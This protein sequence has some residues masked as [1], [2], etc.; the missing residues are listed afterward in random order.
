MRITFHGAARSV[1]GSR[2]LIEAAGS[3]ILLD[4]GLFQGHRAEADAGNRSFGFDPGDL[5]VMV[6]SHAHIDHSG[7]IPNLVKQG[8]EGL[9]V[10]TFATRDLAAIMLPDSAHIQK[11]DADYLNRRNERRG[12]PPVEP[13][14]DISDVTEA[15]EHFVSIPYNR[16]Y[17]LIEGVTMRFLE[18]GH[19]L[20]SAQVELTITEGHATTTLLFSGDLG[21]F[22][23]PILRDPDLRSRPDVLL[24]ES[25]YGDRR[26]EPGESAEERLR[27]VITR[28]AGR[29]GKLIVPA[30]SVGR[31][32]ALLFHLQRLFSSGGIPEIPVFVD[33]PLSFDAT[34]VYRLHPE[35]FDEETRLLLE[36]PETPFR[37]HNLRFTQSV[38]D[39]MELNETPGPAV[40]ISASGM[41]E[42]GRILHH[43][44]NNVGDERNM[45][46][47]VGFMAEHT[48][49]RALAEGR[50]EVRIFGEAYERRAEVASID[51][52]SAHADADELES[53]AR[54]TGSG[55]R[56][57]IL[58]HGEEQQCEAL[59]RRLRAAGFAVVDVPAQ[60]DT[61][62]IAPRGPGGT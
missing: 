23:R 54:K 1:T 10:S 36:G 15:L 28:V 53:Y 14:Y 20:G 8:F 55:A 22:D 61:I 11:Q 33:S 40:I 48:L 42:A 59:A 7:N 13:L 41:C 32:Q 25:T 50:R 46:L 34:E 57:V 45:I 17:P 56:R 60:G 12:E 44:K 31:T 27:D 62:E 2:H 37:F 9:V 26:H 49:G 58:V 18:A 4:C 51:G 6:L 30:F 21:R 3:K 24:M 19:I 35:C 29:G 43:L 52:F 47:I 5:D 38:S 16:P 39:S